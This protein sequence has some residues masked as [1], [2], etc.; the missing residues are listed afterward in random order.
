MG[1]VDGRGLRTLSVHGDALRH[2][3]VT[4]MGLLPRDTGGVPVAGL[5]Q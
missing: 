4:A 5:L 2:E 1:L 3:D